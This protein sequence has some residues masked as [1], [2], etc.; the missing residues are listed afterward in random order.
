M[1]DEGHSM[2]ILMTQPRKISIRTLAE[3]VALELG[4]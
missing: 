3:R 1:F 2:P 4:D